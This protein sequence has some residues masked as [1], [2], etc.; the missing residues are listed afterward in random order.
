MILDLD[1]LSN[2][3]NVIAQGG[4]IAYPTE[5]VWGLGCLPWSRDAVY[6]LLDI[7][8]RPVEK[9]FVVVGFSEEQ[10]QPIL[11]PLKPDD[12]KTMTDTWPGPY[13]WLVPD[14]NN[15]A[16]L[17]VRG[18]NDSLAVRV[19]DHPVIRYLCSAIDAPLIST[20]ANESGQPPLLDQRSVEQQYGG[21][22]DFIV[23]GVVGIGSGPTQI[24][25]LITGR[26]VRSG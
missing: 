14:P 19:S 2:A 20:S 17:W 3:S 22:V 13:T 15:W 7:K 12:R 21:V 4:I 6:R 23:P 5:A 26:V 25:D 9:G 11:D 24:R 8:L 10:F 1:Q 16:P 18:M